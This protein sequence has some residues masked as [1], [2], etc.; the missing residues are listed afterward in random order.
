MVLLPPL[1]AHS[2]E[3]NGE[4]SSPASDSRISLVSLGKGSGTHPSSLGLSPEGA[5]VLD[6]LAHGFPKEGAVA[7]GHPGFVP[8]REGSHFLFFLFAKRRCLCIS[9]AAIEVGIEAIPIPAITPAVVA[10][11]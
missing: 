2:H 7:A 11:G 3:R 6:D 9:F 8:G 1:L 10:V 5:G 4:T